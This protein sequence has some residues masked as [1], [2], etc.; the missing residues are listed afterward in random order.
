MSASGPCTA[1]PHP[2][3]LSDF[4]P[5]LSSHTGPVALP[6]HTFLHLR[7]HP[8]RAVSGG[9]LG[10]RPVD[11]TPHR[12]VICLV[13]LD[14]AHPSLV[15]PEISA[16]ALSVCL[17][18]TGLYWLLTCAHGVPSS[19]AFTGTAP[20]PGG[21]EPRWQTHVLLEWAPS[22]RPAPLS[23][24]TARALTCGD[25]PPASLPGLGSSDSRKQVRGL[26]PGGTWVGFAW[27]EGEAPQ[28]PQA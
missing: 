20:L 27:A 21:G 6:G 18:G 16:R 14:E 2:A 10:W 13:A 23:H 22:L 8:G 7:E 5:L 25:T 4:C 28:A 1:L 9:S 17:F 24:V 12:P 26:E 15:L 19:W 11:Q 3:Q